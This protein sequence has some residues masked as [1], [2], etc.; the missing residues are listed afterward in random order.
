LIQSFLVFSLQLPQHPQA[1]LVRHLSKGSPIVL[2]PGILLDVYHDLQLLD[3]LD[4]LLL[5]LL[6]VQD[7]LGYLLVYGALQDFFLVL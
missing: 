1:F 7:L 5:E 4:S 6:L 3:L 2:L